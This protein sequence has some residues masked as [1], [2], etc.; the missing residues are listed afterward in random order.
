MATV[1][2]KFLNEVVY[3]ENDLAAF[4]KAAGTV[5]M[6]KLGYEDR[7]IVVGDGVVVMD[8]FVY[9]IEGYDFL[10]PTTVVQ[11][12]VELHAYFGYNEQTE[13]HEWVLSDTEPTDPQGFTQYVKVLTYDTRY[14]NQD[15]T[16]QPYK[17]AIASASPQGIVPYDLVHYN[18]NMITSQSYVA[19]LKNERNLPF[20][21]ETYRSQWELLQPSGAGNISGQIY[22]RALGTSHVELFFKDIHITMESAGTG[23]MLLAALPK[24][25]TPEYDRVTAISHATLTEVGGVT[26]ERGGSMVALNISKYIGW[27]LLEV[28]AG[29]AQ[30]AKGVRIKNINVIYPVKRGQALMGTAAEF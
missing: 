2:K 29:G 10:A 23:A 1:T 27:E 8:G 15:M 3:D 9:Q 14:K 26:G 16:D 25:Y 30:T 6:V 12:D 24:A 4:L 19:R 20:Y 18:N 28:A 13:T 22:A 7:N 17:A 5:D 21:P 11:K